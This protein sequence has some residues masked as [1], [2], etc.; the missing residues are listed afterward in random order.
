MKKKS[1]LSCC[2]DTIS[3][4]IAFQYNDL[5]MKYLEYSN[6][7]QMAQHLLATFIKNDATVWVYILTS[8]PPSIELFTLL[9]LF[10]PD[11]YWSPGI[12]LDWTRTWT[13]F[14]LADHHTNFVSQS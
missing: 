9:H 7:L 2:C 5:A 1:L 6:R 13:N 3:C 14:M 12:L 8:V 11:S 10:L 4:Q